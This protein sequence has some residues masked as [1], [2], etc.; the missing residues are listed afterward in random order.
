VFL[1]LLCFSYY[2][3]AQIVQHQ[4]SDDGYVRVP[5]QFP[6]PYY[7]QV[8]TQSYMFSNGVIGFLNPTQSFCC[9]GFDITQP[10]HP[11]TYAIMPLQ[12][13]LINYQGR[14]LTQGSTQ[15]QRYTWEN[16]SEYGIPNNLNTF[17]VEI[18]PSGYIGMHYEKVNLSPWRTVTI[19]MTGGNG[20][21]TQHYYGAG[22]ST[23]TAFSHITETTG[24]PCLINPLFSPSCS[25]YQEAYL[26]QQCSISSLFS[27][28]CPNYQ[29]AYIEQQ[30]LLNALYST[31]CSGYAE[32]YALAN[33]VVTVPQIQLS[34]TGSVETPLTADPVV[35]EVISTPNTTSQTSPTSTVARQNATVAQA[36]SQS[37][38]KEEKKEDKKETKQEVRQV[39]KQEPKSEITASAPQ[40][41]DIPKMQTPIMLDNSFGKLFANAKP[42]RENPRLGR[43]LNDNDRL[44]REMINE[45]WRR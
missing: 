45:Q 5:L 40:I 35:N 42:I 12:T 34:I 41:V 11:F 14:F 39:K 36:V 22:F 19:G 6:F 4:I 25:G 13:D 9:N 37:E 23:N 18:R 38:K 43:M 3:K 2:S 1:A 15:F 24:N 31:S 20:E 8:F 33:I 17:S 30:C 32:A 27:P 26:T 7:G 29:Q 21:Y 16:I 44:H 10:N 28:Q